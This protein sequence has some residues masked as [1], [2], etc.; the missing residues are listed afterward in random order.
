MCCNQN[1]LSQSPNNR[2]LAIKAN[3]H[4]PQYI[5]F[6]QANYLVSIMHDRIFGR[7]TINDDHESKSILAAGFV[8]RKPSSIFPVLMV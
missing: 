8:G 2:T 5:H 4:A 3:G 6:A 1:C 7:A